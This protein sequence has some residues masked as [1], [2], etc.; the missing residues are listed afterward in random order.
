MIS[1]EVMPASTAMC[2]ANPSAKGAFSTSLA[3]RPVLGTRTS[4]KGAPNTSLGQR[5][6]SASAHVHRGPTARPIARSIAHIPLIAFHTIPLQQ[7]PKLLAVLHPAMVLLLSV[8]VRQQHLKVR[9]TNGKCA[10][11]ALPGEPGHSLRFQPV[12]RR[13]FQL[14]NQRRNRDG[15]RQTYGQMHM[16]HNTADAKAFAPS[17]PCDRREIGVQIR[18]DRIG[19]DRSTIFRAEHNMDQQ[20]RERLRHTGEYRSGRW[21]SGLTTTIYLGR[22]PR[23]VWNAPLAL[24]PTASFD[25]PVKAC[26]SLPHPAA[27]SCRSTSRS[28]WN[29]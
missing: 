24:S 21:P 4:A 28:T 9:P 26:C 14:F 19:K 15:S 18:T 7:S 20:K 10:I 2:S 11:P 29:Q 13:G 22:C 16:V 23:L 27:W 25:P 5:P 3:L 12:R 17:V 1:R 6:R 8:D